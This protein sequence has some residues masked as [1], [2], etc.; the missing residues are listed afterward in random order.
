MN[1]TLHPGAELDVDEACS[2]YRKYA[3][4]LVAVRFLDEFDRVARLL[5]DQPGLGT[6]A[7][8]GRS[9]FPLQRFPYSIIFKA[10]GTGIRVLV[11]RHQHRDPG[12][13]EAR[14]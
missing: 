5:A 3:S 6:T 1:Y 8:G 14:R 12:Y 10:T 7:G 13:G 11:L 2:R 4:G 9:S